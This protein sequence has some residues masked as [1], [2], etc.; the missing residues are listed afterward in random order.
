MNLL[1][2]DLTMPLQCY[3]LKQVLVQ[4]DQA[5]PDPPAGVACQAVQEQSLCPTTAAI[6]N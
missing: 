3:V 6:I 5:M 1:L 2:L 4:Q